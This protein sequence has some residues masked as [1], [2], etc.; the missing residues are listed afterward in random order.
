MCAE[1]LMIYCYLSSI[2]Q[3]TTDNNNNKKKTVQDTKSYDFPLNQFEFLFLWCQF[4]SYNTI[5]N[6]VHFCLVANSVILYVDSSFSF[7]S[8][9][10]LLR[11]LMKWVLMRTCVCHQVRCYCIYFHILLYFIKTD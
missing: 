4:N 8:F 3:C 2:G 6:I 5:S 11:L 1:M 9:F 10:F 7:F